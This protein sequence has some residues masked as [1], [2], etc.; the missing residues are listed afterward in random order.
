MNIKHSTVS[1]SVV[2]AIL[3]VLT[4][5]TYQIGESGVSSLSISLFVF[6]IAIF[7]G[8]MISEYF[9]QLKWVKGI[10]RWPVLVWLILISIVIYSA[11]NA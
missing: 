7:K 10:W 8:V 1:A 5:V 11:F 9:M 3:I 4:L 2:F 6:A